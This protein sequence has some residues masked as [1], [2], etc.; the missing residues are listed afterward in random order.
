MLGNFKTIRHRSATLI[1]FYDLVNAVEPFIAQG[2]SWEFNIPFLLVRLKFNQQTFLIFFYLFNAW[3][4]C[5]VELMW[6]W[7]FYWMILQTIRNIFLVAYFEIGVGIFDEAED[8]F[9][10]FQTPTRL[11]LADTSKAVSIGPVLNLICQRD[12][13][14]LQSLILE[15]GF[16]GCKI[17][18]RLHLISN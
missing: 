2:G 4:L 11:A 15:W 7:R 12:L 5:R 8:D 9:G 10:I 18:Y 17:Q 1:F 6:L 13:A 3:D 16:T 14:L